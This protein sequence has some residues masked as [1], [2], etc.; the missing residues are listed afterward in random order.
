MVSLYVEEALVSSVSHEGEVLA[1]SY[2]PDSTRLLSGGW[3]GTLRIW[4]TIQ[5]QV[6]E[7]ITVSDKPITACAIAPENQAWL[8]GNMD[9]L[10]SEWRPDT[11]TQNSMFLAHTR[12]I[13]DLVFSP[14][15][16][17]FVSA[18]WDRTVSLWNAQDKKQAAV[19]G[20]HNDIVA[21]CRFTPDG[22]HL[23]SW[24]YDGTAIVWRVASQ[25][26]VAQL[27]GHRDRITAAAISPDGKW[28]VS[29]SRDGE[30]K[31]WELLFFQ[32]AYSLFFSAEIRGCVFLLDG[33]SLVIVDGNGQLSVHQVPTLQLGEEI[34][35]GKSFQNLTL[36]PS[37]AQLA[38]GSDDGLVSFVAVDGFDNRP[39]AVTAMQ[40]QRPSSNMFHRLLGQHRHVPVYQCVCPVCRFSFGNLPAEETSP[41]VSSMSSLSA[42]E[43][44]N[45][46]PR[47]HCYPQLTKKVDLVYSPISTP[48][49]FRTIRE[50]PWTWLCITLLLRQSVDRLSSGKRRRVLC[51]MVC[52]GTFSWRLPIFS[53]RGKDYGLPLFVAKIAGCVLPTHAQINTASRAFIRQHINH[54]KG[55]GFTNKAVG[56]LAIGL[57]RAGWWVNMA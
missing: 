56:A 2:L 52:S 10:L 23:I 30:L 50:L 42:H 45:R 36:S 39:L 26:Q 17:Q 34:P 20:C 3:D 7:T 1:C 24:S 8:I 48:S 18:S 57:C 4:D 5:G 38:L 13:S 54:I 6:A 25:Q 46:K 29:G 40:S 16:Q 35:T 11:R 49:E 41:L 53:R 27:Q 43:R 12:P 55:I 37:G 9:G 14:D 51:V 21:G 28:F 31:L 44:G 47:D 33:E 15:G 19:L 22:T 32:E